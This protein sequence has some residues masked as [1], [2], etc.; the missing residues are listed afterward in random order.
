ME[1]LT[2]EH[3]PI[4]TRARE[5]ET[6]AKQTTMICHA[7]ESRQ[8]I[9]VSLSCISMAPEDSLIFVNQHISKATIRFPFHN[10]INWVFLQIFKEVYIF[11]VE[12][13]FDNDQAPIFH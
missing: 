2:P 12:C 13:R 6:T 3:S 10:I 7:L 9:I 1:E 5:Q 8:S 11:Q 4:Q